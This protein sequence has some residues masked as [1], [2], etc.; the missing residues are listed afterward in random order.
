MDRFGLAGLRHKRDGNAPPDRSGADLCAPLCLF[1]LVG[2]AAED[3][4]DAP[5]L[6]APMPPVSAAAKPAPNK[7]GR[8]N[9]GQGHSAQQ[10]RGHRDAKVILNAAKPILSAEASGIQLCGELKPIASSDD[11]AVWAHRILGAKNN[12]TEVDAE[13]GRRCL[14]GWQCS[15]TSTANRY[16][17]PLPHP[18]YRPRDAHG[19][20]PVEA[21]GTAAARGDIRAGLPYSEPRRFRDK[22]STT[23]C[24]SCGE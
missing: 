14:P 4:I 22:E 5:D 11:A 3:D 23:M 20:S 12:L 24:A 18:E 7:H 1:T 6:K 8:L 2:I 21:A 16:R 13:A 9:G 19:G 17:A 10:I 15:K